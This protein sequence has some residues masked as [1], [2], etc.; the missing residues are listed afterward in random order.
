M[1]LVG[2]AVVFTWAYGLLR[3]TIGIL[4]DRTPDSSDL[5]DEIRSA[6]ERDG[7]SLVTDL[8]VWHVSSSSL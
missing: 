2:S 4:L 8:H 5:P 7:D 6:V 3:D 1:G